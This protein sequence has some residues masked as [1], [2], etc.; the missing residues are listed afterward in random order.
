[1]D[2]ETIRELF[3]SKEFEKFY[4]TLN[5][6]VQLKFQYTMDVVR[7]IKILS[8]KFVKH[9]DG[10]DLYEMRVSVGTNEYRTILFAIDNDNI[11]SCQKILLLNGFLKKDTKDYRK[12]IKIANNILRRY[13][14]GEDEQ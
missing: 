13:K 7:T 6:K 10:T 4:S 5:A 1:M 9:L 12:Q 3:L 8:Q 11:I 14:D 2:N